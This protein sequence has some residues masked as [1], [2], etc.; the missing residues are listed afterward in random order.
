VINLTKKVGIST[1]SIR[2]IRP[3]AL[4]KGQLLPANKATS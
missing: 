2:H 4:A 3:P 1:V